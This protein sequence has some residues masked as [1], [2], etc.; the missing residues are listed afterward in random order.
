[1]TGRSWSRSRIGEH[2]GKDKLLW[3]RRT[4]RYDGAKDGAVTLLHFGAVDWQC[5]VTVNGKPVGSHEGGYNSFSFDVTP[6]LM[7]G[8]NDVVVRVFDPTDEGW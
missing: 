7:V 8:E 4:F 6:Y 3:Y 1:M 2:Y 5:D